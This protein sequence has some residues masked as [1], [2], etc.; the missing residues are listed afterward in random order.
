MQRQL[1]SRIF[2]GMENASDS[3]VR[4]ARTGFLSSGRTVPQQEALSLEKKSGWL[5]VFLVFFIFSFS[6]CIRLTGSAG[7]YKQGSADEEP[8]S[9]TY[10]F[11]TQDLVDPNRPK[12]NIVIQ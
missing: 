5:R 9:K 11:D 12:G 1:L 4:P 8:K 3:A 7:Y 10:S 2:N 6:G